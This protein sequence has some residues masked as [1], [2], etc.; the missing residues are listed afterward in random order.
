MIDVNGKVHTVW[1]VVNP[2]VFSVFDSINHLN[3]LKLYRL[4]NIK[5]YDF[6]MSPCFEIKLK[7]D[8]K[9][10]EL[11]KSN[12][13]PLKNDLLFKKLSENKSKKAEA[14]YTTNE[15]KLILDMIEN[16]VL[17]DK[18]DLFCFLNSYEKDL[19]LNSIKIHSF[20]S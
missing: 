7:S 18:S 17:S 1:L 15:L 4:S 19:W 8:I 14:T 6:F 5:V 16:G 13:N 12:Q 3:I 11:I 9:R 10:S 2:N 20:I